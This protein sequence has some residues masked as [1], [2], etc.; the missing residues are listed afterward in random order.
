MTHKKIWI[1]Y[2]VSWHLFLV[3][4]NFCLSKLSYATTLQT[5][6]RVSKSFLN[7]KEWEI[8]KDE[9]RRTEDPPIQPT[10]FDIWRIHNRYRSRMELKLSV[11]ILQKT[12]FFS[13]THCTV[14]ALKISVDFLT[15]KY[16]LFFKSIWQKNRFQIIFVLFLPGCSPVGTMCSWNVDQRKTLHSRYL[17]NQ[18]QKWNFSF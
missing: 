18:L 17:N 11:Q 6:N 9:F 1:R 13:F 14:L 2:P 5:N 12:S 7:R 16:L 3:F 8:W 15:R 10:L 4:W